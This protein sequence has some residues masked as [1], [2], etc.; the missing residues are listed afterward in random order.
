[1]CMEVSQVYIYCVCIVG[2]TSVSIALPK[3]YIYVCLACFLECQYVLAPSVFKKCVCIVGR[4]SV[5]IA[6]PKVYIYCVCIVGR[7]SVSIALP[8]VCKICVLEV[9]Q[10]LIQVCFMCR[11]ET[12]NVYGTYSRCFCEQIC[13]LECQKKITK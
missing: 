4:T 10:W 6:L 8:I 5:S 3:V 2:R 1:M 9:S 11:S 7:T 12:L 13:V